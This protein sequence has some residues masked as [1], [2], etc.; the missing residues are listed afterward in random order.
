V[1]DVYE[2]PTLGYH[3]EFFDGSGKTLAVEILSPDEIEAD[4]GGGGVS[5]VRGK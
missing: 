1:V 4:S 3:I 5:P 2:K